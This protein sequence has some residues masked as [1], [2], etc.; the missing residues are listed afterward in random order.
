MPRSYDYRA[1]AILYVDDE[2]QSLKYFRKA[3]EKDFTILTSSNGDDALAILEKEG[4]AI[5]IVIADQRMPGRSGVDVLGN[6]RRAR[7]DT[8]R[9]LTTAYSDLESAIAAVNS[10]AIYKYVVKPW[11]IPE[12]GT[13]LKRAMEFL[14]V[15]RERD[16]L[17][18]EKLNVLQRLVVTDRVRSLAALAGGW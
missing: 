18:R 16:F 9:I 5:G 13:Q 2:E 1:H 12:L 17:L 14:L 7:P 11:D 15:Q 3:F 6:V 10:G 4:P 8:I